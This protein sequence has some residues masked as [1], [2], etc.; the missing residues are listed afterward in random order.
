MSPLSVAEAAEQTG[1]PRRTISWAINV[2]QLPAR[3]LGAGAW[4][5]EPE[6][7]TEWLLAT[8][9]ATAAS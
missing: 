5:I 6:D 1:V 4:M 3:Q 2:G 9:R 7:L 8:G